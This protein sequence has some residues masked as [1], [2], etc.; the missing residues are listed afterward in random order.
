MQVKIAASLEAIL[1]NLAYQSA[2][3]KLIEYNNL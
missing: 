2:Y 1:F 3:Y